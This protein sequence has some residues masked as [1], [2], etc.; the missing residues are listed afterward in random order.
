MLVGFFVEED[1]E[2]GFG[3]GFVFG[4]FA[5]ED[6]LEDFSGGGGFFRDKLKFKANCI[7]MAKKLNQ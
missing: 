6:F 5:F 2:F 4:F 1:V 3:F 7:E